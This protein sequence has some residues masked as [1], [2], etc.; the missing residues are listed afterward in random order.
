[1]TELRA[2]ALEASPRV[3]GAE[4]RKTRAPRGLTHLARAGDVRLV[5]E[6][7]HAESCL[8]RARGIGGVSEGGDGGAGGTSR[9]GVSNLAPR[10]R[11]GSREPRR[12]AHLRRLLELVQVHLVLARR[13]GGDVV[14]RAPRATTNPPP[15]ERSR[16]RDAAPADPRRPWLRGSDD[17]I[18]TRAF[19]RPVIV[20]SLSFRPTTTRRPSPSVVVTPRGRLVPP[21]ARHVVVD[22]AARASVSPRVVLGVGAA[23]SRPPEGAANAR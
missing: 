18:S 21:G 2:I 20:V 4:I 3:R 6:V 8:R 7:E 14:H 9:V 19:I 23:P 10:A 22:D 17:L 15:N 13:R 1:M 5:Q 11:R 12:R 16:A